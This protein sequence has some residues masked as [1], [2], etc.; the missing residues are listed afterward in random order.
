MQST[1]HEHIMHLELKIQTLRD[2]LTAPYLTGLEHD[3]IQSEIHVA[4]LA[5]AHYRKAFELEHSFTGPPSGET[6][7]EN[8][9]AQRNHGRRS[10]RVPRTGL[11][12]NLVLCSASH[13]SPLAFVNQIK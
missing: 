3:R 4:E 12:T 8:S 5:L 9:S 13:A 6:G 7:S 2:Q 11:R 1:L 10:R